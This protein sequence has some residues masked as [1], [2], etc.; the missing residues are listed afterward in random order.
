MGAVR[1][2]TAYRLSIGA[3]QR[4]DGDFS[5][6]MQGFRRR[7]GDLVQS[8]PRPIRRSREVVQSQIALA[9]QHPALVD[10]QLFLCRQRQLHQASRDEPRYHPRRPIG[11]AR[12]M[13]GSRGTDTQDTH[14]VELTAELADGFGH[15]Y[16]P[17]FRNS[18]LKRA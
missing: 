8:E 13:R 6:A 9:Q 17:D 18:R 12:C 15:R 1:Q 16:Q 4:A 10:G 14:I 5:G 11:P 7:L 3:R 2:E